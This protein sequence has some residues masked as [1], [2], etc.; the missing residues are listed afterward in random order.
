M[1]AVD[2]DIDNVN[3]LNHSMSLYNGTATLRLELPVS[4]IGDRFTLKVFQ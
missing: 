2:Q 1:I 3:I 4:D